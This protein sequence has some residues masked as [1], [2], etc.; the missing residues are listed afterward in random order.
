MTQAVG[1]DATRIMEWRANIRRDV[2]ANY[3]LAM[4]V[5]IHRTGDAAAALARLREPAARSGQEAARQILTARL[6]RDLGRGEEAAAI[7][8]PLQESPPRRALDGL[9]ELI[10]I[11]N[12]SA[13]VETFTEELVTE[14]AGLLDRDLTANDRAIVLCIRAIQHLRRGRRDDAIG[15]VQTICAISVESMSAE[16]LLIDTLQELALLL[17]R[18]GFNDLAATVDIRTLGLLSHPDPQTPAPLL[19]QQRMLQRLAK[20]GA[21]SL[22]DATVIDLIQRLLEFGD[23]ADTGLLDTLGPMAAG[24]LNR[25]L[26]APLEALLTFAGTGKGVAP[27]HYLWLRAEAIVC[28]PNPDQYADFLKRA[29]AQV[30]DNSRML[31]AVARACLAAGVL[32][33]VGS[34]AGRA[35]KCEPGHPLAM[36]LQVTLAILAGEGAT[37]TDLCGQLRQHPHGERQ[38]INQQAMALLVT[39]ATVS[40]LALADKQGGE[41]F[42]LTRLLRGLALLAAGRQAEAYEEA[43]A[44]TG[45]LSD[46]ALR[47]VLNLSPPVRAMAVQLLGAAG[48]G[49]GLSRNIV[50]VPTAQD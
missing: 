6:L 5:A 38:A 39:G 26:L 20:R 3:A 11:T 32:D 30:P 27:A 10:A 22:D 9:V 41:T 33:E 8:R 4:A 42:P 48:V 50:A 29:A 2:E 21:A 45:G 47:R 18:Q 1:L 46:N 34:L 17:I 40:A 23:W 28:A 36:T 12:A 37:V 15:D 49:E 13:G 7:L 25:D 43:R 19:Y 14:A 31:V 16:G 24:L 35:L 44:L